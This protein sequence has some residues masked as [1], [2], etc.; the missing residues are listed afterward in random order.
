MQNDD[1]SAANLTNPLAF[2]MEILRLL[3]LSPRVSLLPRVGEVEDQVNTTQTGKQSSDV[4][5]AGS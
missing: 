2:L 1:P 4:V 3:R 5:L